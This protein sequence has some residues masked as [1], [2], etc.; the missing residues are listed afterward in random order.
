MGHPWWLL[1]GVTGDKQTNERTGDKQTNE[2]T[3]R[4]TDIAVL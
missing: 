1:P 2:R 3:D 4:E